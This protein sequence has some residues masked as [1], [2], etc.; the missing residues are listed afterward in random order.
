MTKE[1]SSRAV[2]RETQPNDYHAPNIRDA[3][4][5]HRTPSYRPVA[6][7]IYLV[8]RD[9]WYMALLRHPLVHLQV[10]KLKIRL[11]LSRVHLQVRMSLYRLIEKCC[12]HH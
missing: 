12:K 6:L 3:T 9:T 8:F 7:W 1:E 4:R 2:D 11:H 10:H 5:C